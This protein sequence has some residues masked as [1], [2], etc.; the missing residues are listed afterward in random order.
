M[1]LFDLFQKKRKAVQALPTRN[2]KDT[3]PE[4]EKKYYQPEEY[5]TDIVAEGTPFEKRVVTFEERKKTAI[6]S[7]TGLYPAEILLLEYCSKGTYPNPIADI[8]DFGGSN[9]A[10]VMWVLHLSIWKNVAI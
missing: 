5:Y 3:I 7:S 2:K 8:P 4:A 10:S 9:M 6:P 1:G